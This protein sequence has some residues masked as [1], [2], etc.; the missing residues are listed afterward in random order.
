MRKRGPVPSGVASRSWAVQDPVV[1][2]GPAAKRHGD[3]L[4]AIDRIGHRIT[5]ELGA[6]IEAPQLLHA[7]LVEGRYPAHDIAH[8]KESPG[9]AQNARIK[10][11]V[12]AQFLAAAQDFT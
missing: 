11:D 1:A 10:F 12:N 5:R 6:R 7:V 8:E 4:R 2:R 3:I 9:G